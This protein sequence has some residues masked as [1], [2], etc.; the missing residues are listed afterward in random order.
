[1]EPCKAKGA[2]RVVDIKWTGK[3]DKDGPT[4]DVT[5]AADEP[6][7]FAKLSVFYYDDKGKQLSIQAEPGADPLPLGMCSGSKL[8]GGA[9]AP[10]K[11]QTLSF[12]CVKKDGVPKGAKSIE[13]E[14]VNVGF[15]DPTG[16]ESE[17]YWENPDLDPDQR[18]LGG[19]K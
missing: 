3:M 7:L 6:I 8:F 10:G 12:P 2:S 5:S 11:K 1:M 19:V 15:A 18:P 9:L 4:F 14:A 17:F 13:V 16:E